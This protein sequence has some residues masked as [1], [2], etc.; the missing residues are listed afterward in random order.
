MPLQFGRASKVRC[1]QEMPEVKELYKFPRDPRRGA[2]IFSEE[3][4]K[5]MSESQKN[6]GPL[7]EAQREA[8]SKGM[9]ELNMRRR[10]TQQVGFISLVRKFQGLFYKGSMKR[11]GRVTY[12]FNGWRPTQ[13]LTMDLK[14]KKGKE[15]RLMEELYTV[16]LK[17]R[18]NYGLVWALDS[19]I[20]FR[21]V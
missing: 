16:G 12:R 18:D 17:Q 19:S 13:I 2:Y 21:I 7:S 15:L 10:R 9:K 3:T 14:V 11:A 8:I 6:R 5:K 4:R 20:V 1:A